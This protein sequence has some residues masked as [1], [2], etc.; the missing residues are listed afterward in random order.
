MWSFSL[1][2]EYT[3]HCTELTT[4]NSLV[5]EFTTNLTPHKSSPGTINY[6]SSLHHRMKF[7]ESTESIEIYRIII[8]WNLHPD[9]NHTIN[10]VGRGQHFIVLKNSNQ[11]KNLYWFWYMYMLSVVKALII[12]I[13]FT[14]LWHSKRTFCYS[15][16]SLLITS[17]LIQSFCFPIERSEIVF[18]QS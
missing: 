9:W 14:C 2:H 16:I 3:F 18:I 5:L 7:I 1:C 15:I 4:I 6:P 12:N 17:Q 11:P 13:Q 10:H 8:E